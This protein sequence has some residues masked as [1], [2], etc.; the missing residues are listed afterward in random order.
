MSPDSPIHRAWSNCSQPSGNGSDAP[1]PSADRCLRIDNETLPVFPLDSS[2]QAGGSLKRREGLDG[3]SSKTTVIKE[4]ESQSFPTFL[5]ETRRSEP[6][7]RGREESRNSSIAH[8]QPLSG[9]KGALKGQLGET[10]HGR[11]PCGANAEHPTRST[12]APGSCFELGA[13]F[14]GS[15]RRAGVPSPAGSSSNIGSRWLGKRSLAA[16][17]RRGGRAW[18]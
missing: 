7:P 6:F 16:S 14:H 4:I 5:G 10:G 9:S 11:R 8:Q 3:K 13:S 12:S 17:N 2:P 1:K 15:S 18:R